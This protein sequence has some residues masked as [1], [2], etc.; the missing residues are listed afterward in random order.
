MPDKVAA[1]AITYF[2]RFFL[3]RSVMDYNPS[4]IAL[5]SI[6]ASSKVEE[7]II[8]SDVLVS[9]FD[10][11][12]N[13]VNAD[14]DVMEV[15]L[16]K[17]GT[18]MRVTMDVLLNTELKFL[19]DLQFHLICYHPLKSLGI[20]REKLK[21]A[22]VMKEDEH[23]G[24]YMAR[25][26]EL[27][28]RKALLSDMPLSH[29]PAIIAIA[30]A[31]EAAEEGQGPEKDAILEAVAS[32]MEKVRKLIDEAIVCLAEL[33]GN[34]AK[35]DAPAVAELERKRQRV[36]KDE[37]DPMSSTYQLHEQEEKD[38]AEEEERQ[39]YVEVKERLER[40]TKALLGFD[41]NGTPPKRQ[42]VV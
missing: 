18:S 30:A 2:K 36:Q 22:G 8:T 41:T 38:R 24:E 20:V 5:S 25:A 9:R 17:D 6:Y 26:E 21:A 23:M 15:P 37:N 42:R 1:T 10:V 35:E 31:I 29:P 13:G 28:M 34:D 19:Q 7:V 12:I 27:I 33:P 14:V 4:V 32:G 40:K 3:T 16:S 39:R 11:I